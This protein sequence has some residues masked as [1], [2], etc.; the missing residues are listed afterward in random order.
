MICDT[1][2]FLTFWIYKTD[3]KT[4][5]RDWL[6]FFHVIHARDPPCTPPFKYMFVLKNTEICKNSS[7]FEYNDS[8]IYGLVNLQLLNINNTEMLGEWS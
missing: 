5:I 3:K 2:N 1:S 7:H 8:K 6:F 4:V